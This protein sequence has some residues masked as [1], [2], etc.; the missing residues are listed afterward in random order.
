MFTLDEISIY[1]SDTI[2]AH[3]TETAG[4]F[5]K[6][7]DNVCDILKKEAGIQIV[8]NRPEASDWIVRPCAWI[9]EYLLLNKIASATISDKYFDI[10]RGNYEKALAEIKEFKKVTTS[11]KSFRVEGL[12]GTT[13]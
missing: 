12:L 10:T 2:V 1:L 9:V 5:A 8:T 7:H 13:L 3:L 4:M 6:V 11:I